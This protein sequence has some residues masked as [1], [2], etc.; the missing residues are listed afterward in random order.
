MGNTHIPLLPQPN[1]EVL[2]SSDDSLLYTSVSVIEYESDYVSAAE[3]MDAFFKHHYHLNLLVTPISGVTCTE[4]VLRIVRGKFQG[5]SEAYRIHC[6]ELVCEIQAASAA[7]AIYGVQTVKQLMAEDAPS[8]PKCRIEDFPEY[9]WRGVMLDSARTFIEVEE[10]YRLLDLFSLLKFN[11]LHWHLTDDQGWRI[12][13]KA[14]PKLTEMGAF[15]EGSE[16]RSFGRTRIVP[17]KMGGFYTQ[18]QI[19]N[20]VRY[21]GNLGILIVPEIDLPGHVTAAL[22]AYPELSCTGDSF[23]IPPGAGIFEDVLC[24]GKS[25]TLEFVYKVLDEISILF[26]SPWIHLGG[27]EIPT[28]RW[29]ECRECQKKRKVLGLNH[30]RELHIWFCNTVAEYLKMKNRTLILWNDCMDDALTRDAFC[31]VWTPQRDLRN[32]ALEAKKTYIFSDYF[33]SYF[34]LPHR[35]TGVKQVYNYSRKLKRTRNI[36]ISILGTEFLLWTEWIH[37]RKGRDTHLFP[38]LIAGSEVAWTKTENSRY[39]HFI[40]GLKKMKRLME[41]QYN[42]VFHNFRRSFPIFLVVW[43]SR[44]IRLFHVRKNQVNYKKE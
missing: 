30:E 31:Q 7:G 33:H 26:P 3:M 35:I 14:Y 34:D 18:E 23:V 39:F 41:K 1:G 12:E 21:A 13:I 43:V 22:N 37:D 19:R 20:I 8:I 11:R 9:E 38:R 4:P 32:K 15:R 28:G 10:I 36:S 2:I 6:T 40:K 44:I 25:E 29:E 24:L 42:V 27:D 5:S 17:G 16:S